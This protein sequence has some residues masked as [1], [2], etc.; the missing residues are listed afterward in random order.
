MI[1]IFTRLN[2]DRYRL[3]LPVKKIAYRYLFTD[4][5]VVFLSINFPTINQ[6]NQNHSLNATKLATDLK[7]IQ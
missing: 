7:C 4:S 3:C 2:K 6:L 5:T 1:V